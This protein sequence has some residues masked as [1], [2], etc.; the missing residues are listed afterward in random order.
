MCCPPRF[1]LA[2]LYFFNTNVVNCAITN[3]TV[4]SYI[5]L[6][7]LSGLLFLVEVI[8]CDK[9]KDPDNGMVFYFNAGKTAIFTCHSGFTTIGNSYLQ[10]I[11]GRWNSPPPKCQPS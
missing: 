3:R 5:C 4:A 8:V 9:L 2:T 10:C 6:C 7:I 11:D 1:H